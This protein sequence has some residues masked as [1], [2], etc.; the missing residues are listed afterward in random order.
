M[1]GSHYYNLGGWRWQKHLCGAS[2]LNGGAVSLL[3][4]DEAL[5]PGWVVVG[6]EGGCGQGRLSWPEKLLLRVLQMNLGAREK[7]TQKKNKP[8]N[9][10]HDIYKPMKFIIPV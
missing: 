1:K 4:K 5:F 6:G 10:S 8:T 3:L 9:I 7:L 2:P